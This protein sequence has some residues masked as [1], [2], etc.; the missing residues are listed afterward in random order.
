MFLPRRRG[1][2]S[3][4]FLQA[5]RQIL[6]KEVPWAD[7]EIRMMGKMLMQPRRVSYMADGPHL[8][9]T[10]SGVHG[11]LLNAQC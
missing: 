2:F 9:Y 11:A 10:Y 5:L 7:R 3:P 6:Q 1:C 4:L 8:G